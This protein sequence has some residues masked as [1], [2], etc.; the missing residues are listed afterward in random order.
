MSTFDLV[1]FLL[2]DNDD[3]D[4]I[5]VL[6]DNDDIWVFPKPCPPHW[7]PSRHRAIGMPAFSSEDLDVNLKFN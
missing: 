4:V 3:N 2:D 5:W 7:W 6:D 1:K